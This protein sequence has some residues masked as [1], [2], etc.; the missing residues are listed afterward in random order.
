LNFDERRQSEAESVNNRYTQM[1]DDSLEEREQRQTS[2]EFMDINERD[3]LLRQREFNYLVSQHALNIQSQEAEDE[4]E[5]ANLADEHDNSHTYN[6][7]LYADED[8]NN[9]NNENHSKSFSNPH[10]PRF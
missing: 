4:E 3:F 1:R 6:L 10:S 7:G 2:N 8:E 5:D 9:E